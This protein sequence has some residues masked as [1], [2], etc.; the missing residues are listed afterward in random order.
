[1]SDSRIPI[2]YLAPWVDYGGSDKGTIDWFRNLDRSRFVASLITTQPSTN[3][4][5]A[6]VVPFADEV[7]ALPDL[8]LGERF[9]EFILDFVVSREVGVVHVMN[10]RLGFDLLPDLSA[11]PHP[12][13]VVVQLHVEETTRDGYVRY[14]TSRYGNLVDAFSV[15][16]DHL[17]AAV[18][19]YG[20]PRAKIA[21]IHTGVDAEDEFS[22]DH[23]EPRPGLP[24]SG[25][26]ILYPGRL[27][28]QKDP[29]LM[30]EV[31][32]ELL[33]RGLDFHIHAVG[34]GDL[35]APV[36]ERVAAY[37]LEGRVHLEPPTRELARWYRAADLVL[38]TSSFEG[39]PYVIY[40][41]LAMRVPVVAPALPGNRELMAEVGGALVEERSEDAFA[42]ALEPLL[43]DREL[44]ERTG[45]QG[46]ARMRESFSLQAMAE[47]HAELYLRL[48]ARRGSAGD[49]GPFPE[50]GAGIL[51]GARGAD[52]T[53]ALVSIVTPC[54]NHGHRL[55]ECLDSVRQQ[56]YR[57]LEM[58]VVDDGS[59]DA[60][61]TAYLDDLAREGAVKLVRL[62]SN[63]GP[64]AARNRGIE[65]AQGRYVLPLDADNL[66]L[67]QAVQ[68]LVRQIEAAAEDVG[69]IYQ[70]L[71][72]FGTREDY[73]E[74]PTF[75]PWLLTRANFVDTCALLDE[76]I[77]AA[78]LRYPEDMP[79]GHEDWDFA[80]TLAERGIRGEP[81][82]AKTLLYG[83]HGFS[84]SD[85]VEWTSADFHADL[86]SRH[87]TMFAAEGQSRAENP[88]VR[89]KARWAPALSVIALAEEIDDAEWQRLLDGVRGQQLRDFELRIVRAD[90][91]ADARELPALKAHAAGSAGRAGTLSAA[92]AS[93]RA[94]N[95]LVSAGN[96]SEFLAD[97]GCLERVVR[98]LEDTPAPRAFVYA[99]AAAGDRY[100]FAPLDG[101]DQ[102][103]APHAIAW[104]RRH[105]PLREAPDSY[106]EGDPVGGL[107]RSLQLRRIELDWRQLA[108]PSTPAAAAGARVSAHPNSRSHAQNAELDACLAAAPMLP[109]RVTPLRRWA[110]LRTWMPAGTAPLV[111][112]RRNASEEWIVSTSFEPPPGYHAEHYLGVIHRHL[113]LG[114]SRIVRDEGSGYAAL[115]PGGEPDARKMARTLGYADAVPLPM[116]EPLFLCR[117]GASGS[118]VLV[119]GEDDPILRLV[120]SPHLA[121]LGWID[122]LPVNPRSLAAVDEPHA[123]LRGLVR[124]VDRRDRRHR[125]ALGSV[126]AMGA[127]VWELG[128]LLDRDPGG[129]IPAWV[130]EGGRLH[131]RD[132]A[133][134]R[135]PFDLRQSLEWVAEP[136]TWRG[137]GQSL[138]RARAIA[139]RGVDAA[140]FTL[141]RPGIASR[142]ADQVQ[143]DGW[144]LAEPGEDRMAI[145]S[146][147]HAVTAD[148]LVT[149]DA[150][151]TDE[152]GYGPAQLIG[153]ALSLAPLTGSLARPR[154][155]LPWAT[156][157]G[158]G[159]ARDG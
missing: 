131:T 114:T 123:W 102:S 85:H 142:A 10:S 24:A 13:K 76:G 46:R 154:S 86:A 93:T 106:D 2:L 98:L 152:L 5:L 128:A 16:S 97:A 8:M 66:L 40:E 35:E 61:T 82:S 52:E 94:R 139:R 44:R 12:P 73:L 112:H 11:L 141:E 110:T 144:L 83:K 28:E 49:P 109:G 41:A 32:R 51:F 101:S 38:M 60:E 48:G 55:R 150:G 158:E 100:P 58:I 148:Q 108:A 156:R 54:F 47:A 64:G 34:D 74:V 15:T 145:F 95:V 143:P 113:S 26:N 138:P 92:L 117:H 134:T 122:R 45:E 90:V 21:V 30:V 135:H 27:V 29:L 127:D 17:A 119:C 121:V 68:M 99:D 91:P 157:F 62:P 23:L 78:G 77:F 126:P 149:S 72:F 1:V 67:P 103:H 43:R 87:P 31:A 53:A 75:N 4:R 81:M 9:A 25:V 115:A 6:E 104:S 140:R 159:A 3:P 42:D 136:A 50:Q 153:Y 37:G 14:V 146:A 105:E 22:P 124:A 59:T 57:D 151:E 133:P 130:D 111:R 116:L 80:V 147:V 69:F 36:R 107:G 120:D 125:V 70:N 89:L 79:L 137:F 63:V 71:Q 84:R 132:Y 56:T 20:I 33:A 129:G 65:H 19:D 118:G 88:Q 18:C 39:V 96:G 155:A 7:W